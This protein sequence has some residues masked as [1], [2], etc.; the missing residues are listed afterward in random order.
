MTLTKE[1]RY[2]MYVVIG[3]DPGLQQ[4]I[5]LSVKQSDF[6]TTIY[7]TEKLGKLRSFDRQ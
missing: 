4:V 5:T 7:L 2:G 3:Q 1:W 6:S